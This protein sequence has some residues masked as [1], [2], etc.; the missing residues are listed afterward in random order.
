MSWTDKQ[1]IRTICKLRDR[2]NV[3]TFVETGAFMG[4][5]AELHS[6]NFHY[7]YTCE[8]VPK[9]AEKARERLKKYP[10]V[11]LSEKPSP[12]FIRDFLTKYKEE[13]RNDILIF[14]L[15]AHFYDPL[16]P[17]DQRFVVLDELRE[18]KNFLNGIIII[19]DFDNNLGHITYD[20]QPL[21]LDLI[22]EELFKINPNFSLYTNELS[23]CDIMKPEETSDPL[24]KDNLEYAWSKPEKTFR[25]ILY[26]IPEEIDE[27]EF[28][29]KK[30]KWI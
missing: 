8:K 1:S 29:L 7:V 15:D 18:L 22:N 21:N 30:V 28:Q 12:D 4:V 23:T 6:Q 16:L 17:K 11:F 10:N 9:Y 20:G 19:H 3:S 27:K 26:C 13:N 5:N 24:I 2:F 25:G 14:Y